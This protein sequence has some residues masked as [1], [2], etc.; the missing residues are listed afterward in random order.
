MVEPAQKLEL[1]HEAAERISANLVELEIDSGRR[2]LEATRLEGGSATRWSAASAA[3]TELWREHGLLEQLLSRADGL[4]GP[5]HVAELQALLTGPS[6]ELSSAE[7]PLAERTLLGHLHESQQCS[8]DQL[9]AGMSTAF[10]GVKTVIAEIGR[11]WETLIPR[12]D[13]ARRVLADCGRLAG[14]IGEQGR[15]DLARAEESLGALSSSLTN[16]PLSVSASAIDSLKH[17]LERLHEELAQSAELKRGFDGRLLAAR[18]QLAQLRAVIVEARSAYEEA[19]VKIAAPAGAQAPTGE[20]EL[21]AQLAALAES[22]R[23][24]AWSEARSELA[25][26][27]A[28]VNSRL[29]Q[30]QQTLQ[31]NRAPIAARDQLRSLLE[32]YQVKARRLGL[33]EDAAVADIYRRTQDVLYTAPTDLALAAQLLRSYQQALSGAVP[34]SEAKP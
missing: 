30:A 8:P 22:A 26:W 29:E 21:E 19:V 32:A 11:R 33:L 7:V 16:D 4:R 9:L 28:R 14:E 17:D 6:I 15:R 1:L 10:D 13:E 34:T 27:I 23:R 20:G 24:G 3:L 5:K 12:L 18:D 31:A 2:L 25:D